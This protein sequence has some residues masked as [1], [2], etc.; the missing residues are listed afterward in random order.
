MTERTW[1]TAAPRE[2]MW[3]CAR[4]HEPV[5]WDEK[6][7]SVFTEIIN[8]DGDEMDEVLCGRCYAK[9]LMRFESWLEEWIE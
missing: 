7:G 9:F 5:R 3:F 1:R 6:F 4:C 2:M 8:G